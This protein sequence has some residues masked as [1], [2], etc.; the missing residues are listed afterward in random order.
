MAQ[1]PPATAAFQL[2]GERLRLSG[3]LD[4]ATTPALAKQLGQLLRD[5]PER[6]WVVDL[7]GVQFGNSAGIALLLELKRLAR[8]AGP[9]IRIQAMPERMVTIARAHGVDGLLDLPA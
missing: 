2:D 6:E 3:V 9:A 7:S 1:T 4:F 5:H 8:G